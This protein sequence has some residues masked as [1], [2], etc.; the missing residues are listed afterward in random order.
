MK[1]LHEIEIKLEIQ[2]LREMKRRLLSLGFRI[3]QPRHFERNTL[4]DF[5]DLRLWKA[6]CLLRLRREGDVWLLTFKG[7]PARSRRYKVR[8]EI[9]TRLEDGRM[10]EE[11]LERL[12]LSP[13]FRYEK[14]RTVYALDR[15]HAKGGQGLL[16]CDET[17]IGNYLELE[18]PRRWI[19]DVARR[20]GFGSRDFI[21]ASYASL[22]RQKSLARGK[23]LGDMVFSRKS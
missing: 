7:A 22:H 16:L 8:R 13:V 5:P 15:R 18:G 14:F 20:L 12:G 3:T 21:T 4:F 19:D 11:I 6:R 23:E 1:R 9:E 17:P 2:S 10:A